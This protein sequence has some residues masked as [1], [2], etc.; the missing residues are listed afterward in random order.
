MDISELLK[1][2][3]M[4]KSASQLAKMPANFYSAAIALTKQQNPFEA[5]KAHEMY[6]D[7][8]HM[9]QHKM[10]MACIRELRGAERAENLVGA[11]KIAYKKIYEELKALQEGRVSD[12]PGAELPMYA[13]DS[14]KTQEYMAETSVESAPEGHGTPQDK[15]GGS[16]AGLS[17]EGALQEPQTAFDDN[18][19][20]ASEDIISEEMESQAGKESGIAESSSKGGARGN[21]AVDSVSEDAAE[22]EPDAASDKD[23]N[24]SD[25]SRHV[26]EEKRPK[27]ETPCEKKSTKDVFKGKTENKAIVRVRFIKPMPAFVGPEL[28]SLGPFEEGQEVGL[29][30][31]IVD[32]LLNNDAVEIVEE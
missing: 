8:V 14:D 31:T 3:R 24:I 30:K 2:W 7:I 23:Q 6:L 20:T 1:L 27:E 25:S 21:G 10:L 32:I 29:D 26:M 15:E 11:E 12:E 4:E 19:S 17:E 9:R 18:I 28:N 22:A 16:D 5:K 13:G